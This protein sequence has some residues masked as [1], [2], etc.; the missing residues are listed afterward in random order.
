MVQNPGWLFDI[1][2]STTQFYGDYNKALSG[3][4][5]DGVLGEKLEK[6]WVINKIVGFYIP[7]YKDS[8]LRVG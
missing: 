7:V 5:W 3:D 8:L 4:C 1:R 2:D 6:Q